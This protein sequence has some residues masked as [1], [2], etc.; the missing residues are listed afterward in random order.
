MEYIVNLNEQ[1]VE[2]LKSI[3]S[4]IE[5]TPLI[6]SLKPK[7]LS[8]SEQA[9]KLMRDYKMHKATLKAERERKKL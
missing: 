8:K 2:I 1:Q 7:K 3:L 6:S 5:S 4:Q 9:G